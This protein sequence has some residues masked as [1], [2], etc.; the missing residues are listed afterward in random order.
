MPLCNSITNALR[1]TRL[2]NPLLQ[3]ANKQKLTVGLSFVP[4][5][6]VFSKKT[7]NRVEW[8]R[9]MELV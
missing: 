6:K 5:R 2:P 9:K 1:Q 4:Q 3:S 7:I 8:Q